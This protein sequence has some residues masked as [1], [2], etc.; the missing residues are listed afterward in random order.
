VQPVATIEAVP[1][2]LVVEIK[3]PN[4]ANNK[5]TNAE[6]VHSNSAKHQNNSDT[7]NS[8]STVQIFHN[9]TNAPHLTNVPLVDLPIPDDEPYERIPA[10]CFTMS[11]D[12]KTS[13]GHMCCAYHQK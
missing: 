9:G 4:Q 2:D 11:F 8:A 13:P 5:E 10:E 12:C 1:L 6:N 7:E 3:T